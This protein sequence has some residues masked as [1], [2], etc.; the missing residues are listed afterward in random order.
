MIRPPIVIN[1]DDDIEFEK[2]DEQVHNELNLLFWSS[3]SLNDDPPNKSVE[4][5]TCP[6]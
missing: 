3:M 5:G 1:I 4:L 6:S 2:I